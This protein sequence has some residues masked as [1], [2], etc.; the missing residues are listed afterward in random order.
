MRHLPGWALKLTVALIHNA[1]TAA[2]VDEIFKEI[3]TKPYSPRNLVL[4][5]DSSSSPA[6]SA[7]LGP[8]G[9]YRSLGAERAL[10]GDFQ[11]SRKR[12]YND[13]QQEGSE[14]DP[15]YARDERQ[16]KQMRRGGRGGRADAVALRNGR[17]GFQEIPPTGSSAAPMNF[18]SMPIPPSLD[19]NDP[20][21]TFMAMQAM[22]LP[23]LPGMP[24][25]PQ[26]GPPNIYPQFGGQNLSSLHGQRMNLFKERC[27]D[28]D[29]KFY[30]ERGD[31]CPYEHGTDRLVASSQD[32]TFSSFSDIVGANTL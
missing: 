27:R 9:A 16:A 17:G 24:P 15:Q 7:P 20:L 21:A 29:E 19:S 31:A 5:S 22:G 28:Y 2:F 18:Q 30:C 25:L 32:G 26:A 12:S 13:G 4:Q 8:A 10:H 23:L 1:D 3:H 11:E 6:F 14:I